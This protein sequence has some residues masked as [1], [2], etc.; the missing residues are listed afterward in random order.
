MG[1]GYLC[2]DDQERWLLVVIILPLASAI[3]LA[4]CLG[5]THRLRGSARLRLAILYIT[6]LQMVYFSAVGLMLHNPRTLY[7]DIATLDPLTRYYIIVPLRIKTVYDFLIAIMEGGGGKDFIA[8]H[9]ITLAMA[10]AAACL[11]TG[12]PFVPFIAGIFQ[13]SSIFLMASKILRLSSDPRIR[14][15]IL[16]ASDATFAV[17]F[18]GV[19]WVWFSIM[20]R[21]FFRSSWEAFDPVWFLAFAIAVTGLGVL[22]IYWGALVLLKIRE[23]LAWRSVKTASAVL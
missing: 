4:R 19:R 16:P 2:V 11:K 5:M 7:S 13:I 21:D 3:S 23:R 1:E 10:T 8:H 12:G 6:L 22:Q 15:Y 17:T 20:A 9:S 14:A 18:I